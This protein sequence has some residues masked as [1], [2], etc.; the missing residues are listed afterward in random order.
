[1]TIAL[2]QYPAIKLDVD[3]FPALFIYPTGEDSKRNSKIS[4]FE[5]V[6]TQY[7]ARN[8]GPCGC[9]NSYT[10]SV[11]PLAKAL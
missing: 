2:L 11:P 1:L 9:T 8:L 4:E 10:L 6:A 5:P 3:V 7:W